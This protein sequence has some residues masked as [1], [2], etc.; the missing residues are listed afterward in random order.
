MKE[1]TALTLEKMEQEFDANA[2]HKLAMNAATKSGI[3]T[4][5]RDADLEKRERFSF[6]IDLEA[7]KVTNQKQ[8]GRCWMFAALNTMR[9]E[10]MTSW[11][12]Q[13]IFWRAFWIPWMS[14]PMDVSSAGCSWH[15]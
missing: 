14:R 12:R 13:I 3:T 11:K 2:A 1:I 6:S 9:V 7:G 4:L 15:R 10:V 5:L 8:S